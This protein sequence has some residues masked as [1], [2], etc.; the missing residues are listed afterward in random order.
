MNHRTRERSEL[1]RRKFLRGASLAGAALACKPWAARTAWAGALLRPSNQGQEAAAQFMAAPPLLDAG[2]ASAKRVGEGVYAVISDTTKGSQT[3]CNGG[4]VFGKEAALLWEGFA[5]PKGAAF[6]MDALR[7]ATNLPVKAAIDSHYH[8]DHSFGN[9]QYAAAGIAIWAHSKVV[10]L[11]MERY[12][13]IQN[14]DKAAFY[15]P[16]EEHLRTA[17]SDDDK[18]HAEGD[19]N[20]LKFL[21]NEIDHT[22]LALPNRSLAPTELP[23]K[24][25]LG[26][27]EV[28]IETY[29]G[30]TPGDLILRV[31]DADVVFTGDL[32]FNHSYPVTFDADVLGWLKTLDVFGRYGRKTL[33]VPGHGA[34]H[35]QEG[36]ELLKSVFADLAQHARQMA[37]MGVPLR[38]AQA[39]YSVPEQYKTLPLFTWGFCI[40]QAVAQ[41][42][43]AAKDGKI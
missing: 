32:I 8:F 3:L 28:V 14:R 25:D 10:P 18:K 37:Q 7:K 20:T 12:I 27:R 19:L 38:E 40:D 29:P 15:A 24:V 36:V 9:A 4:F 5:S 31:P 22:V 2:F 17:I 34:I 33:F 6:Q 23:M 30:H 26:G 41:F 43:Q 1:S 13:A 21:A 35:G 11:M 16:A 39:R 42:Y